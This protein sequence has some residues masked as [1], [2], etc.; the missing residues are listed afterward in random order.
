MNPTPT[1]RLIRLPTVEA[2]TGLK[3]SA[4]YAHIAKGDFPAPRRLTSRASGWR[5]DEVVSWIE[6]RPYS[7]E[8]APR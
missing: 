4:I 3:R 7:D 8:K 6:S 5:E 2:M 1:P